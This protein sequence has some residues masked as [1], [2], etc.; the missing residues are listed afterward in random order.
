MTLPKAKQPLRSSGVRRNSAV[1]PDR[2]IVDLR[3]SRTFY[4]VGTRIADNANMDL[5]R[6]AAEGRPGSRLGMP[7]AEP[8]AKD[9]TPLHPAA[10]VV[11]IAV[12]AGMIILLPH[13]RASVPPAPEVTNHW[14]DVQE[15]GRAGALTDGWVPSFIPDGATDIWERHDPATKE[16]WITFEFPPAQGREM[17]NRLQGK[18]PAD[19]L[20]TLVVNGPNGDWWPASLRGR[21]AHDRHGPLW[22]VCLTGRH[23]IDAGLT[24]YLA[25]DWKSSRACLWR[26]R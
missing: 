21:I 19:R 16:G 6:E 11:L 26:E 3:R 14:A 22:E 23:A 4:P 18:V 7:P 9:F 5:D 13:H 2:P 20:D 15:A 10:V 8:E 12:V 25:I 24:E 17:A 1:R